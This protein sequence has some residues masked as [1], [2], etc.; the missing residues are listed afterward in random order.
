MHATKQPPLPLDWQPRMGEADFIVSDAN[1]EAVAWLAR[2]EVW[3]MPRCL[4]IGPPA[5]GKSHL[6]MIAATRMGACLVEDADTARQ[7][8]PLFHAWN[9]ASAARPLLMTARHLPRFWNHQLPD[10]A[11]RLAATPLVTLA[12]PDDALLAAVLA[13]RFA[14]RGLRVS[15]EVIQ[16]LVLRLERSFAAL[17]HAVERLDALSLAER[18]D[19]T[20]PLARAALEQ[21]LKLALP[22]ADV[23][24]G[25]RNG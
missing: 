5:S 10:L 19:I 9:A 11:S 14:D 13:K 24:H 4:I 8:E 7:G 2:P 6:A 20:V 1:R 25:M 16:W 21:Q 22:E 12:E 3:P 18:R 23:D 15:D 17:G